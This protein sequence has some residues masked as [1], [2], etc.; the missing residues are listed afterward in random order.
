MT[1]SAR[2]LSCRHAGLPHDTD[3]IKMAQ[4][5]VLCVTTDR[6]TVSWCVRCRSEAKGFEASGLDLGRPRRAVSALIGPCS[7]NC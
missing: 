1:C 2:R 4:P 7:T 3:M 6:E 5:Y